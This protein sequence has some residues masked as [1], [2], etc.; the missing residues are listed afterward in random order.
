MQGYIVSIITLFFLMS[1]CGNI[2]QEN[3]DIVIEQLID[4]LNTYRELGNGKP[5]L[6]MIDSLKK[7]NVDM[8]NIAMEY[9]VAYAYLGDFDKSIKVLKDSIEVSSKPQLLYNELGSIY[10][11]KGDTVEAIIAYKQAIN[12]NQNYARPYINLAELYNSKKE[13]ELAVNNYMEAVRLFA[14]FEHYEEKGSYA[15][16]VLQLDSTNVDA[17]K[18]L[19]YYW[20]KEGDYRMALAIG[21]EIDE[22]CVKQN[23]LEEGYANMY[24]M[25]MILFDMGQYAKSISLM[26]QASENEMTAKEYG[27]SIC[28]YV[29]ASYRKLDNNEKADYF[30]DLAKKVNLNE[31]EEYIN[32]LLKREHGDK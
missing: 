8:P 28:C 27:Y 30:L 24:F 16:K 17:N 4:S 7:M 19:Q 26:H 31:A 11:I 21:L 23:R 2:K 29:S 10:R 3:K 14:E 18:F 32:E 20:Y 25:G 9:A 15:S 1:S 6:S 13:K 5:K 12:Y 22:L